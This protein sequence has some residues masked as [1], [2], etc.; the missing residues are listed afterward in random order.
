VKLSWLFGSI[1][2]VLLSS[3]VQAASLTSWDFSP[4]LNQLY[5]RTDATVQPQVQLVFNPTRLVID[6]PG[7]TLKKPETVRRRFGAT[8]EEVRIGLVD[9]R[10]TRL[11]I[12][13]APGYTI[14]ADGILVRGKSPTSWIVQLPKKAQK[15]GL[16][17]P[18][19]S[20][21]PPGLFAGVV[22]LG[23]EMSWLESRVKG[24]VN[25]FPSLKTGMFFLDLDTGRYLDI[26]GDRVFPAAST[27]KLPLLIAFFQDLD[28]GKVTMEEIM[29]MRRK[30]MTV[31]S[32]VMQYRSP[33]TRYRM[34][35]VVTKMIAISDNTATNMVIDRLGGI[36][37]V[38]QRFRSWGLRDTVIRNR[39]ADLKGTN[40]TSSKDMVRVLALVVKGRLLSD[41]SRQRAL[42]IL[43][44]TVTKT[45]LPSGLGRGASIA[46]KTGDIGF[47]VGD[48]GSIDMSNGKR[49]LAAI[50]VRRPYDSPLARR[51][52]RKVSSLVYT[53]LNNAGSASAV[54]NLEAEEEAVELSI[55]RLNSP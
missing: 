11:V 32:G 41:S 22:A 45:L 17:V 16:E 15:N 10:T 4:K 30:H 35:E 19:N 37:R 6:L 42:Y 26:G 23:S 13:F 36:A 48:A 40:T 52:I 24:V 53:Y 34:R 44:Q 55:V 47:L 43:R 2:A 54:L 1:G 12:A 31:G 9:D 51:F 5:F 46:H 18:L 14:A 49:Y 3:P 27:I 50:Y 28:A 25:E 21:P 20:A 33:G 38:N 7:I 39:L 29:V 8:V